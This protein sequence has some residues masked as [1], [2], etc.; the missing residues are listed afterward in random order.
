MCHFLV[1]KKLHFGNVVATSIWRLKYGRR[2]PEKVAK[3]RVGEAART[4]LGAMQERVDLTQTIAVGKLAVLEN[5]SRSLQQTETN[6]HQRTTSVY[7]EGL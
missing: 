5:A 1:P 3:L 7:D 2:S 4:I 6:R